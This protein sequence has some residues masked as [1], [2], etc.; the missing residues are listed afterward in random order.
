MIKTENYTG[1][2]VRRK[3]LKE[4]VGLFMIKVAR[5]ISITTNK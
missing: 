3:A 1:N 4:H 2:I 5:V